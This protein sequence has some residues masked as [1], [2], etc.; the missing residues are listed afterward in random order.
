MP[1]GKPLDLLP[2]VYECTRSCDS[3]F[4]PF[5]DHIWFIVEGKLEFDTAALG[6]YLW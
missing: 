2:M 6:F 5:E 1:G 3:K 4:V